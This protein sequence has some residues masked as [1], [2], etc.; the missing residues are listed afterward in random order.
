MYGNAFLQLSLYGCTDVSL[1]AH[2]LPTVLTRRV[3]TKQRSTG[4]EA[5][6]PRLE[7]GNTVKNWL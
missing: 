6:T 3:L 2:V 1:F 7:Y 5:L 4:Q